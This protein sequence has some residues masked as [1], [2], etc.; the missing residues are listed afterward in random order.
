RERNVPVIVDGATEPDPRIFLRAG[1]DLVITSMHKSF[2]G[3]TGATVAGRLDL[4]RACIYQEK[5]IARPMKVGKEGVIGAIAAVER[6]RRLDR[7]A[8][9]KALDNRLITGRDRLSPL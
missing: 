6:W 4:V 5:G 8:I 9:R 7:P 3:I 1:A 2:A